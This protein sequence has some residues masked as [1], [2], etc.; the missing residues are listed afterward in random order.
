MKHENHFSQTDNMVMGGQ[1]NRD[2]SVID[3]DKTL[4]NLEAAEAT[5]A[6]VKGLPKYNLKGQRMLYGRSSKDAQ[7]GEVSELF[8]KAT[9]LQA[10]LERE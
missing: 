2:L 9:E 10:A 7:T 8:V 6:R 1:G 4:D 3:V 5:I